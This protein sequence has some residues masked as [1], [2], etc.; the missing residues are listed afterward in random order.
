MDDRV[1]CFDSTHR[2]QMLLYCSTFRPA[3]EI[4]RPPAN[5][6]RGGAGKSFARTTSL[7]RTELIVSLERGVFNVPIG[8]FL[9]QRLKGGTS[10]DARFFINI[11][12]RTFINFFLQGKVPKEIHAFLK[13]TLGEHAN[14]MPPSKTGWSSLTLS[15]LTSYIYHVPHR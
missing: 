7:R 11:E 6:V 10:S 3:V 8:S 2:Q 1:F 12:T 9:L 14:S 13:E 4:Y 15:L 5:Q